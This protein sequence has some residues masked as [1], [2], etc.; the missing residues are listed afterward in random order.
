[1]CIL[2]DE[3]TISDLYKN[4][5]DNGENGVFA[6]NG[7]LEV[8]PA[9]QREFI[10][11]DAKQK[12]VIDSIINNYPINV[13]YWG[14]A[15]KQGYYDLIDG[16]QRTLSICK[17]IH[18][19]YSVNYN[20]SDYTFASL[21]FEVRK[22][23]QEYKLKI[24]RCSGTEK[25]K[26]TWFETIN[27]ASE[28][29][30][31]QELR[32]A[33]YTGSWLSSA[34]QY[35]SKTNCPATQLGKG[36]IKTKDANRQLILE[37]VLQWASNAE[38]KTIEEYMSEHRN[39]KDAS[40]LWDYFVSIIDWVK[41][42]F[43]TN[44]RGMDKVQWGNLYNKYSKEHD[45]DNKNR[46]LCIINHKM[47]LYSLNAFLD[48]I[49]SLQDDEEVT[50]KSGIFEYILSGDDRKLS[51]RAFPDSIK[52]KVYRLQGG[53]CKHCGEKFDYDDMVADHIIPWSKGGHTTEGNCQMLCVKCNAKK[54]NKSEIPKKEEEYLCKNCGKPIKKGMFCQF[55]GTKN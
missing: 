35:F 33:V 15:D 24:Y 46:I 23:I 19:D 50:S 16:Q 18:G 38:G 1:M 28:A 49:E 55:C 34:K 13:F 53:V 29:L 21:P 22:I 42:N 4:Y 7:Y 5:E 52:K 39:D 47:G 27:I 43:G 54:L 17:F 2:E 51:I 45:V 41:R 8:R 32:N 14:E 31:K 10:Y 40:E 9:Y 44:I 11:D 37:R 30:T 25:E 26:L 36:F 20:G 3:I 12:K 48:E 6:Y